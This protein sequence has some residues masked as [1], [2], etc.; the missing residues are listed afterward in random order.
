MKLT[1]KKYVMVPVLL[2]VLAGQGL[3]A[4]ERIDPAL[5]QQAMAIHREAIVVD[6]H[7]DTP[8]LMLERGLDIG[9]RSDR[10]EVDLVKMKEG[11]VD[12]SFFAVFV[13]NRLD[14]KHP[15]TR[16]LATIDEIY[17]QVKT[18]PH[19]AELARSSADI[20]RLHQAGKRAILIGMENG[21]PI[22]GSLR[23]LRNFYRLGVRYITLTHNDNNDICD[24]SSAEKPRW[25]G[26]SDFG[27]QVVQEMNRLGM[28][29]D[30]SHISDQAFW[31][32]LKVS[33]APVIASHSAVR[34]LCDVP[35]NMSDDMIK[36]L[37]KKGSVIQIVFYSGFLDEAYNRRAEAVRKKLDP[38]FKQLRE[39]YK[40]NRLGFWNAW[41]EL[42]KKH[43]PEPPEIDVL[44]DHI[45]RVVKLAGIDHVGLGS[46]FD[47]A[48]S[49]P[50]GLEDTA[51]F[52]LI[53]YHL[54]KRGYRSEE[55]KKILGENLL[56][57]FSEVERVKENG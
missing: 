23:L 18:Y 11:G 41:G 20:R 29:I 51:G 43:G 22:E 4:E 3:W 30:V 39:K 54:L 26:L 16:A 52:P 8:M 40:D 44:I 21:G 1:L 56:R 37:A 36:A 7:C 48:G 6:T 45:D 24:S 10:S 9:K 57:V 27:K 50:R 53:T 31:D 34:S 55:I 5:W 32:V 35:R 14:Q 12:A 49:F 46:D 28:I 38:Q 25:N 33:R 19:L 17:R 2:L 13:S 42:W 15:A 47:G